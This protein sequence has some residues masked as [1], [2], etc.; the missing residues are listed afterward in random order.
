MRQ[1]IHP[2]YVEATVTCSCG[3]SFKTRSTKSDLHVELCSK[4]H[5]FYTGTQ[6][7]VDSGGRVQRFADKFGNAAAS[8]MEKEAAE[9]K[10][11]Q[12]T[13]EETALSARQAREAKETEKAAKAAKFETKQ[14]TAAGAADAV[15]D[16]APIAA[17]AA[18]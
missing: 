17:E 2:D 8:V 7:L 14:A 1:G 5:P 13:A 9:R 4:C 18:E 16:E 10:A 12:K 6:K 15:G 11:R 3:E